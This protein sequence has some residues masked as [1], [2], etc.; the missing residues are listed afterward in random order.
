MKFQIVNASEFKGLIGFLKT[1]DPTK[2]QIH[3]I[4]LRIEDNLTARAT[5]TDGFCLVSRRLDIQTDGVT[6]LPLIN[7][8]L[9]REDLLDIDLKSFELPV[10][11]EYTPEEEE[12]TMT[13]YISKRTNKA[14][15]REKKHII[16]LIG[17]HFPDYKHVVPSSQPEKYINLNVDLLKKVISTRSFKNN[18]IR[19][20]VHESTLQPLVLG[21]SDPDKL[22][23]D[24]EIVMPI[25]LDKFDN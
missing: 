3:G 24:F 9:D 11:F 17:H 2:P 18:V 1:V 13:C 20:P 21:C 22:H 8:V 5:V 7:L 10:D 15:F 12:L 23:G 16:S 14:D 19:I 4:E 25:R 6:D